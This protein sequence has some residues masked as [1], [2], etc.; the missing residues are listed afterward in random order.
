MPFISLGFIFQYYKK[1]YSIKY[2]L[3]KFPKTAR[4]VGRR[5]K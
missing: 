3:G 4:D 5:N 1:R 2:F